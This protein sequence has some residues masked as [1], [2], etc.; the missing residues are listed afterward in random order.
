MELNRVKREMENE[1]RVDNSNNIYI[2]KNKYLGKTHSHIRYVP[3]TMLA[4][5]TLLP[6]KIVLGLVQDFEIF[7]RLILF[8]VLCVIIMITDSIKVSS[9]GIKC[10]KQLFKWEEI[11]TI[12]IAVTSK[13]LPHKLYRKM[14]YISKKQYNKPVHISYKKG[15]YG[16]S[17][18]HIQ[19]LVYYFER[20]FSPKNSLIIASFNRRLIHHIM[21]Y[22]G[23][24]I[25][26][27]NDTVGW[28]S[29]VKSYNFFH[30]KKGE[31]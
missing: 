3:K 26:N 5:V 6:L 28:Y 30:R 29:Y 17:S 21:A 16:T 1:R 11:K 22:W 2:T 10:D 7:L 23:T 15:F 24:D 19:T 31:E 20:S 27:L 12:G 18:E 13:G 25:K 9:E 8:V 14:I 4:I